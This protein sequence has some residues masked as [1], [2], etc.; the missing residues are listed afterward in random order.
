VEYNV[1]MMEKNWAEPALSDSEK[2]TIGESFFIKR[3]GG[4]VAGDVVYTTKQIKG[5]LPDGLD[6]TKKN[7]IIFNSSEDEFAA[8]G[9][10]HYGMSLFPSQLAGVRRILELYQERTDIHFYLRLHPNLEKIRYKYHTGY[11]ELAKQFNNLTVIPPASPVSSYALLDEAEK[12]IIFGSTIGVESVYW[13]KP[14]ILLANSFYS[15]LDLFYK[16]KT[17]EELHVL[18]DSHLAPKDNLPAVKFGLYVMRYNGGDPVTNYDTGATVIKKKYFFFKYRPIRYSTL[19][20]AIIK[21]ALIALNKIFPKR[22]LQIPTK[23]AQ[24]IQF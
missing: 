22:R 18:I 15:F 11:Y 24:E 7:I 17:E 14:V 9:D 12:V 13:G 2:R 3:R 19:Y 4:S 10:E 23:E 21:I 6:Q 16:P 5:L 8:V 1:A 20:L